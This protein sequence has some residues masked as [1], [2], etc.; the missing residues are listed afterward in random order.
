MTMD[1]RSFLKV[2]LALPASA[3]G[4]MSN[5]SVLVLG[6]GLAGLCA[7]WDLEQLGYSVT[8][9]D[10]RTRPGGRVYTLRHPFSDCLYAEAGAARIQ[11]SHEFTLR[12]AKLFNLALDPFFPV[13]GF[14]VTVAGGKR[15]LVQAGQAPDLAEL[16]L[17]FSPEERKL[18]LRGS[19][20]KYLFSHAGAL[21][22]PVKPDWPAADLS[23]FECSLADF[24]QRQG[25]SAGV[26]H[27][28]ALGHDLGAMSA[29]QLLR[30]AAIGASTKLWYKIRGGNDQL[31]RAF[32]AKLSGRILYSA[33][34]VRIEQDDRTVRVVYLQAGTPVILS[35]DYMICSLPLPVMRRIE[36]VPGLSS[37][38]RA[39]IYEIDYIPMARVFLQSR[40]RFWVERG[41][42]GWASTDDPIDVWD[43]TKDQPGQRGILGA[44]TSGRM[45][46]RLT[47]LDPAERA[48][49][50]LNMM[51]R[52]H[53]GT[54]E[55][56]EGSASHSWVTDA[57]SFGA[58]AEFKPRQLSA[59]YQSMRTPEGR[60]HFAGEHT[61]PWNG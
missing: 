60:I 41:H 56:Y 20:A 30:D 16:P 42:N 15:I 3:A 12:Y 34:V 25:A 50:V 32:A 4:Q 54:R 5:T 8:I 21:G 37:P 58:A 51:E 23:R 31:P 2:A 11:D 40:R 19:F 18:G 46:I 59:F 39:A 24:M 29:L 36:V 22:D 55:N 26:L 17:S 49:A 6:A 35:A 61:S 53:P 7:A 1:R 9:L 38:K 47:Y 44:Y 10:A 28:L 13:D 48:S 52:V 45:A 27:M 14:N 33:E 57:W 43:Y